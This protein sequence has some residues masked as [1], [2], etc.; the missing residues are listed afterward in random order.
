MT[1]HVMALTYEP[2][3]KP[4]QVGECRQTIRKGKKFKVGDQIRLHGWSGKPYR[5]PWSWEAVHILQHVENILVHARGIVFI[6]A[7]VRW[8]CE[9]EDGPL[10]DLARL[11]FIDPPSGLA[12]RDVLFGL[13]GAPDEPEEYQ[14]IRW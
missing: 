13:N 4:V 10:D 6:D 2:K 7:L 1:K 11:D 3:I 12:L 14:I 9:W 8:E 5:T